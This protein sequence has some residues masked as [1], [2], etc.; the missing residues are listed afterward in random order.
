MMTS[1]RVSAA[2]MIVAGLVA[3]AHAQHPDRHRDLESQNA[4]GLNP[5]RERVMHGLPPE[6]PPTEES[7]TFGHYPDVT[8]D[9]LLAQAIETASRR[10]QYALDQGARIV[11][12]SDSRSFFV[13]WIPPGTETVTRAIATISGHGSWAFDEFYLWHDAAQRHGCAVIA[14][15]WWFGGGER[16]QD[17]YAPED[18]Y[19]LFVEQFRAMELKDHSVLF[20]GFSRGSA[21]SYAMTF[22]DRRDSTPFFAL[23]VANSGGYEPNFPMHRDTMTD[24]SRSDSI[25]SGTHWALFAGGRDPHPER[26]GIAGM[27]RTQDWIKSQG[28]VIDLFIRDSQTGHGGFHRTPAHVE[29]VMSLYDRL[30]LIP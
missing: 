17:Y 14:L 9:T 4:L 20:H 25:L 3:A 23:T 5:G 21:N 19:P 11:P 1:W 13:V 15:Q 8:T 28:G 12:T 29:S 2:I 18:M 26:S 22:L 27:N 30:M 10:Y 24:A 16:Y 6:D 7:T